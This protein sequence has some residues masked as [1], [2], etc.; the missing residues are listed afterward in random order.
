MDDEKKALTWQEFVDSGFDGRD[1][2]FPDF[3]GTYEATIACKRW[4]KSRNLLVYLDFDDGRKVLTAAWNTTDFFGLAD[5]P[6]GTKVSVTFKT[7][8]SG[9]SFLKAA[10]QICHGVSGIVLAST[11]SVRTDSLVRGQCP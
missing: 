5:M 11:E 1:Y 2:Q 3:E 9:N 10:E 7:A 8:K 6:V 4:N